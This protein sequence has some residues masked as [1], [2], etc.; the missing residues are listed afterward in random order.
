RLSF[1]LENPALWHPD[2]PY[3]YD[4]PVTLEDPLEGT[5]DQ[6]ESYLGLR[7]ITWDE[8]GLRLNGERLY[9]RGVL[10]QGYFPEGWYT[11]PS[12]EALRRDVELT[13]ALGF[14]C[15]RKHQK[16][17]DPRYLYWADRLGL[18]VWAEMP[19]GRIFSTDLVETLTQ[20]WMTLIRRDRAH[21]SIITWVPFN[22]S[23]GVWHQGSRPEQRAW[24]DSLYHL[25]KALDPSRPVVGNDGWEYS[26]GDLW[27]LHLY[28]EERPL[29]ARRAALRRD[30]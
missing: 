8:A 11:A 17:E 10:D 18:L 3:L 7:E 25:T 21:P 23:W 1:T 28:E 30:P 24:V 9:L 14:N 20:E 26:S 4:L 27:T 6:V 2:H 12:D 5:R 22:E 16:A 19:S 13:L 15:A 29:E